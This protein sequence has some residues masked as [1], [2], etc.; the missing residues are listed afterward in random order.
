MQFCVFAHNHDNRPKSKEK[1]WQTLAQDLTKHRTT[2]VNKNKPGRVAIPLLS[3]VTYKKDTV[4]AKH[5]VETVNA[6]ALDLDNLTP[7]QWD[8]IRGDLQTA[9]IS[10][11]WYT[12]YSHKAQDRPDNY[13]LRLVL[14]LS[15]PVTPQEWSRIFLT[16]QGLFSAD[17]NARD[18]SRMFYGPYIPESVTEQHF[19][20]IQEGQPLD[21]EA[22][23]ATTPATETAPHGELPPPPAIVV[24][25]KMLTLLSQ[26]LARKS[27]PHAQL[28][29][30][31]LRHLRDGEAFTEEGHRDESVFRYIIAAV[32]REWPGLDARRFTNLATPSLNSSGGVNPEQFL[33][34]LDRAKSDR[35]AFLER[36]AH[37]KKERHQKAQGK[38]SLNRQLVGVDSYYVDELLPSLPGTSMGK[39]REIDVP[40]QQVKI[41]QHQSDYYFWCDGTYHGP[42]QRSAFI[43]AAIKYLSP[44]E[45]MERVF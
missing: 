34:K 42:S 10:S 33:Y 23:L 3:F 39:G 14:E 43:Q 31:M 28:S 4:R 20:G 41:V 38:T 1:S 30:Q 7:E 29:S 21:V 37:E 19:S 35:Q 12:T 8:E 15:R 16:L 5:N 44:F 13:K 11:F 26:K 2:T 27:D 32:V 22:L 40:I 36:V 25:K 6:A 18:A 9:Q 24:T 45:E 17:P